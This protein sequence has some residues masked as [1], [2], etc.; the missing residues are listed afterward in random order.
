[1]EIDEICERLGETIVNMD[2]EG[3]KAT[4]REAIEKKVPN[5]TIIDCCAKG[6]QEVGR[7][8]ETRE[9]FVPE[10]I[11]AG[12]VMKEAMDVLKP[13]LDASDAKKKEKIVIGTV[14]GDLHDIGKNI[15]ISLMESAGFE[16]FDLGIDVTEDTF[17]EKLKETGA[18]ILGMSSLLTS[19]IEEIKVVVKELEKAGLRDKVKV[20]V[21]G[22]AVSEKFVQEVGA[23]MYALDA[24]AGVE[25]CK[26]LIET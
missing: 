6:M 19:T 20:I 11:V 22:S 4:V 26:Q 8:Y 25:K 1:M 9:Y 3:A 13:Y 10:L 12:D 2:F 23:D 5:E 15:F 17:I 7:R 18:S 14:K 21:G 24:V 16:V